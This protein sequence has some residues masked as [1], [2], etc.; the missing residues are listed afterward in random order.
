MEIRPRNKR[1]AHVCNTTLLCSGGVY[2]TVS[3]KQ[4]RN[5]IFLFNF[6]EFCVYLAFLL[7]LLHLTEKLCYLIRKI[8]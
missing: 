7:L 1:I 4:G 2:Y 3:K 5:F 6:A 8:N